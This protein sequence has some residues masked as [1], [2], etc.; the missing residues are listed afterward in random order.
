M[1]TENYK[2]IYNDETKLFCTKDMNVTLP[3]NTTITA[4]RWSEYCHIQNITD[5][6]GTVIGTEPKCE[7]LFREHN[8]TSRPA[9]TGLSMKTFMGKTYCVLRG[10]EIV[11]TFTFC[12]R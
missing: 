11:K 1:K 12:K 6:N 10:S 2:Y 8:V 7:D 9:I 5:T 3:D 4:P